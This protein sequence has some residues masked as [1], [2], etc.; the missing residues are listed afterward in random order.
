MLVSSGIVIKGKQ[1]QVEVWGQPP[2]LKSKT[3]GSFHTPTSTPAKRQNAT[4]NAPQTP[5]GRDI[6]SFKYGKGGHMQ[7]QCPDLGM[8]HCGRC[9]ARGH[10]AKDCR[11]TQGRPA[12]GMRGGAA[13][14]G[15][16]PPPRR[17]NGPRNHPNAPNVHK[18]APTAPQ[19]L[20]NAADAPGPVT[21]GKGKGAVDP[22]AKMGQFSM[23]E[24]TKPAQNRDWEAESSTK[25]K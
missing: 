6:R 15:Q 16:N 25:V 20:R 9:R 17:P 21:K 18:N 11:T 22:T 4:R 12:L 2:K 8:E 5:S 24:E 14:R 13:Q 3:A 23:V 10:L 1:C 7:Y 19:A